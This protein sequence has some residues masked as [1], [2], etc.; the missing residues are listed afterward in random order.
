MNP[1]KAESVDQV[2]YF[3]YVPLEDHKKNLGSENVSNHSMPV[4]YQTC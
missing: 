3:N 2:V 4:K 1:M